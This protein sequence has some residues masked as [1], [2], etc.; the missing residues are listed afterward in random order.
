MANTQAAVR[1]T[2]QASDHVVCPLFQK[3]QLDRSGV[4]TRIYLSMNSLGFN[5]DC[6]Q[7]LSCFVSDI[8]LQRCPPT[9]THAIFD[10]LETTYLSAMRSSPFGRCCLRTLVVANRLP[11]T[12]QHTPV[13]HAPDIGSMNTRHETDVRICRFRHGR[14][15]T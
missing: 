15:R 9:M 7:T 3:R 14:L 10:L 11:P 2:S 8:Q 5:N 4:R 12:P 6:T 13:T 1:F